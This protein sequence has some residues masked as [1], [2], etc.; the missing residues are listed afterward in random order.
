[1]PNKKN[2]SRKEYVNI[3]KNTAQPQKNRKKLRKNKGKKNGIGDYNREIKKTLIDLDN[4]KFLEIEKDWRRRKIN[5]ALYSDSIN[6]QEVINTR[7]L[8]NPEKGTEL[9]DC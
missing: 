7:K 4:R 5:E 1:M 6:P 9:S 8:T 3:A 2:G